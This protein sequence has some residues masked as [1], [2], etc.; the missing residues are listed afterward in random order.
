MAKNVIIPQKNTGD[1]RTALEDNQITDFT[2]APLQSLGAFDGDTIL[3][4]GTGS[5]SNFTMSANL[6]VTFA[7][8]D[9]QEGNGHIVKF[10]ADGTKTL[11]FTKPSAYV[12]TIPNSLT[13]GAILA[14]G[15]YTFVFIFKNGEIEVNMLTKQDIA[16]VIP[17]VS[18]MTVEDAEPNDLVVTLSESCTFTNLGGTFRVN[19]TPRAL[20][21]VSGSPGSVQTFTIS[22]AAILSTNTLD[23][24]YDSGTGDTIAV[25]V[26][27]NELA[28]FAATTVTNNVASDVNLLAEWDAA[29]DASVATANGPV[30]SWLDQTD[31]N[32]DLTEST[33]TPVHSSANDTITFAGVTGINHD[34]LSKVISALQ[35]QQSDDFTVF[36]EGLLFDSG[37]G[38]AQHPLNNKVSSFNNSGWSINSSGDGLT[39]FLS[40]HD[41]STQNF[42]SWAKGGSFE[43]DVARNF[44]F[45][46]EGGT[47][48]IYDATN[49]NVGTN[50]TT[51]IGTI[52][53]GVAEFKIGVKGAA[54]SAS[55]FN[56][57]I[58]KVKV[59]DKA[60]SSGERATELGL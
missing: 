44:I 35:F 4:D 17:T 11:T 19:A 46:N 29:D 32:E 1:L 41:N 7:E 24:A 14:S 49:T 18:S 52:T 16:A 5:Y 60:L 47:L 33:D 39:L 56:G 51:L 59:W 13:N 28:T 25:A 26:P 20:S 30:T 55:P 54:D 12:L 57:S 6:I 8:S 23:F 53:Y 10:K 40:H 58:K 38:S 22:G 45:I 3:I 50:G 36:I 34:M 15:I 31:N 43:D 27:N 2:V 9:H 48:K 21:A 42:A 37:T